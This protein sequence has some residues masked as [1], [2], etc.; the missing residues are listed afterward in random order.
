MKYPLINKWLNVQV[1]QQNKDFFFIFADQVEEKLAEGFEV[2]GN[3]FFSNNPDGT[4]EFI[5]LAIGK[6]PIK[7]QTKE[8]AALE[9][10]KRIAKTPDLIYWGQ[11]AKEVLQ[12]KD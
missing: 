7:K 4:E 8:E 10:L 6:Q 9:L 11:E 1:Y 12:M 3:H 5:A 2:H